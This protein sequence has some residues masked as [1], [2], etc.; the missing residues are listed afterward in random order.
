[1]L[2][3]VVAYP[4]SDCIENQA[5]LVNYVNVGTRWLYDGFDCLRCILLVHRC[6]EWHNLI[7][8]HKLHVL[9]HGKER[10][11]AGLLSE[12][13]AWDEVGVGPIEIA[14]IRHFFAKI[15]YFFGICL[16]CKLRR[17]KPVLNYLGTFFFKKLI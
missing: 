9:L 13:E 7:H 3:G 14:K 17:V 6:V 16:L 12:D 2:K 1:V 4:F 10:L 8:L 15:I 11:F 5:R